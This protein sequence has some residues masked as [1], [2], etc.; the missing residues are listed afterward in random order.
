MTNIFA[1]AFPL[2]IIIM[3]KRTVHLPIEQKKFN[4]VP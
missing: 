4:Y 2:M 1:M 3:I